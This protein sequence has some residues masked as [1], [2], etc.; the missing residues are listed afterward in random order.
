[1]T[2]PYLARLLC[3]S[4][5]SFF[6]VYLALSLPSF[7]LA[8]GAMRLSRRIPARLAARVLLALRL[9]PL[10]AALLT[11][12]G[13]CLPSYLLLEPRA[14]AE[15]IGWVCL[16]SA[17]TGAAVWA[18]AL[19]RTLEALAGKRRDWRRCFRQGARLPAAAGRLPVHVVESEA[20]MLALAGIFR[21]RIVVSRGVL[22]V[23]SSEELR[24]AFDHEQA[25]GVSRDNLKR[26]LLLLAPDP[27][28]FFPVLGA[29]DRCWARAAEWA[30]DD[31]AAAGDSRRSLS[32]AAAL[33]RVARLGAPARPVPTLMATLAGSAAEEL[34]TRVDRLLSPGPPLE[35]LGGLLRVAVSGVAL[36]ASALLLAL[37]LQP[38]MLD[39]VHRLLEHLVH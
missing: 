22:R 7:A 38:G 24:A 34:S 14:S 13:L 28:P 23:L 6:L 1:M 15:R 4:F 11:V 27:L 20:P 29:L 8:R 31:R 33:V 37:L 9:G 36:A 32:L 30:A 12:V 21:P 35:G 18:V 5:G 10:V 17:L 19:G 16:V 2:S 26:L 3:L 39:A 25:H